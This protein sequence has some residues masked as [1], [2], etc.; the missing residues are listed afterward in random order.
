VPHFFASPFYVYQYATSK[1]AS[2]LI[3]R[4]ITSGPERSRADAVARYIELLS[5]GGNDHPTEQLRRAGVDFATPEPIEAQVDKMS[6]LVA[7]LEDELQALGL[8]P[9]SE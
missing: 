5:A 2:S 7:R 6:S 9:P 1:A 4:A 3:H 8:R